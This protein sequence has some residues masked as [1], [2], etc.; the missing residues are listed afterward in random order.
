MKL[1]SLFMAT[2][3]VFAGSAFAQTSTQSEP[4]TPAP[5][6]AAPTAPNTPPAQ[7]TPANPNLEPGANSF[8]EAQ[9]KS[10]LEEAGYTDV[11]GLKQT[12]DGIWRGHARRNGATVSVAVDYKGTISAE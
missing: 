8:T 1:A 11:S 9:A 2:A 4:A 7:T 6:P 10:W 5:D 3:L 12:E